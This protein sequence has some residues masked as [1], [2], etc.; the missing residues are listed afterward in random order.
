MDI[1]TLAFK[2]VQQSIG[3]APIPKPKPVAADRGHARAAK[4]SPERRSDIAKKAATKR[5][6]NS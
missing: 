6:Q 5:W 3:A 1:N 2:I 4:L